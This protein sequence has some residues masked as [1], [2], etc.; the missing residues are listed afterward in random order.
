MPLI[1]CQCAKGHSA[2][3][4]IALSSY[5]PD[6]GYPMPPC[7]ECGSPTVQIFR[8][9]PNVIDDTL[10]GGARWMHN[11]GDAAV[12]VETKTELKQ[13][14]Q[15][16]GLVFAEHRNYSRDDKTPYASRTRLRPGQRDPFIHGVPKPR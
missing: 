8:G 5:V 6:V 7:G 4:M 9:K 11:L 15:E 12:W 1:D 14:M 16:R 2:E 3:V 13:I 10:T